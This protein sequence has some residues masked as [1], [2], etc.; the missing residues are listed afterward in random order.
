[1]R[2]GHALTAATLCLPLLLTGCA[3]Q[4][5]APPTP[6][7]G[8][9]LNGSV[10]GGQQPI[11]GAH[12][13][14]LAANTNGYGQPSVSLLQAASTG[15]SDSLGAYVIS[16]AQGGFSIT[17]DYACTPNTQVYLYAVGGNPGAG[18]NS[19]AGLLAALGNCPSSGSFLPAVPFISVNEVTT[20]AA[21]YAM[22]GFATDATHVSSSGTPQALTGIANAFANAANLADIPTGTALATTP[23][24]NG[25]VPNATINTLANIL[26]SCINSA[27]SASTPCSTLFSNSLSGGTSGITPTDT[28]TAIINIAHNPDLNPLALFGIATA[29]PPFAPALANAPFSFLLSISFTA[30]TVNAVHSSRSIAVDISGNVWSV[31]Q[32]SGSSNVTKL[33]PSGAILSGATGYVLGGDV[34][35]PAGSIAIDQSGNAWVTGSSHIYKISSSGSVSTFQPDE[36]SP[37]SYASIAIDASGNAWFN[38]SSIS[39]PTLQELAPDGTDLHFSSASPIGNGGLAIDSSGIVWTPKSASNFLLGTRIADGTSVNV[40][41]NNLTAPTDVA[42]DATGKPWVL[43]EGNGPNE[44]FVTEFAYNSSTLSYSSVDFVQG[45]ARAPGIAVDGANVV[46]AGNGYYT[47]GISSFSDTGSGIHD[48]Y[49]INSYYPTALALDPSG[50]VWIASGA[51]LIEFIGPATPVI[52][53]IATA[54]KN[55]TLGTRP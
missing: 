23:A 52:T 47:P 31:N 21:A 17:G 16:N 7:P 2:L 54:L 25:T 33:S 43:S 32:T 36:G 49:Y 42:I 35:S 41:Q 10:H 13:Y 1:M 50:N 48:L 9:K 44:D 19:A 15:N 28:A 45:G 46:W 40:T 14:L 30:P 51:N 24:G 37:Y 4:Q 34:I 20:V 29:T 5:T 53:P 39:N 11:V 55:N 6:N 12:I 26:A 27:G 38:T 8:I 22:A 3:L 18:V